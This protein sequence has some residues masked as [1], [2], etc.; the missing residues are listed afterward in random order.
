VLSASPDKP[1]T[2]AAVSK[3]T[4]NMDS[5][6]AF[7]SYDKSQLK[8]SYT[9]SDPTTGSD[10]TLATSNNCCTLVFSWNSATGTLTK[11]NVDYSKY[12]DGLYKVDFIAKNPIFPTYTLTYTASLEVKYDCAYLRAQN[13]YFMPSSG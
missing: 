11:N 13:Q 1:F 3:F 9:C 2:L 7:A 8:F 5:K 6:P 10:A 4:T 12:C